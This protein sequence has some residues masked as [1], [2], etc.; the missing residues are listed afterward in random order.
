MYKFVNDVHFVYI[1]KSK[2]PNKYFDWKNKVDHAM[3]AKKEIFY[4]LCKVGGSETEL[5]FKACIL[6]SFYSPYK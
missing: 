4:V 2:I 5:I 1:F 6:F 3:E